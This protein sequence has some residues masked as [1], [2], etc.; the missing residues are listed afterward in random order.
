MACCD[1]SARHALCEGR[2]EGEDRA[3]SFNELLELTVQHGVFG[4]CEM[5]LEGGVIGID[6]V[7]D[8]FFGSLLYLVAGE[9]RTA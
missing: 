7:N 8:E 4:R 1:T 6:L 3:A 5:R 2:E 9:D